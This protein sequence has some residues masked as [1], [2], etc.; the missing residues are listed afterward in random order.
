MIISVVIPT[1]NK[2]NLLKRTL[3]ELISQDVGPGQSWEV[4]VVDDGSTD[5][6]ADFLRIFEAEYQGSNPVLRV[7]SPGANLGRARAR[8]LGARNATGCWL[9]FLDDDIVPPAGLVKAHLKV[10]LANPGFGTIG[11]AVTD[12]DLVDAPHFHYLDTRG[13]ARLDT[14]PAPARFFVTQNAAV[15]R[16]AFLSVGGFDEEFSAYGFEDMEVAFRLED[17][18]KVKFLA[19]P[20]PVPRHV[21]HHTLV[22]YLEKKRECGRYSLGRIAELHPA[23]LR[24]MRLHF[25]VNTKMENDRA[26]SVRLFR[27]FADSALGK[28]FPGW[29]A[30]WPVR[31]KFFPR[32]PSLYF[33]MMNLAILCCFRQGICDPE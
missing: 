5:D 21:H 33:Q 32:W 13:V 31:D 8:N 24:E 23:R 9:L 27:F 2:V 14:G 12:P 15:P 18:A 17:E 1:M 11:F 29:L 25:V 7:V 19:L 10:L 20:F 22:Q 4:V 26:L 30:R 6:T 16:Q 28:D 3:A